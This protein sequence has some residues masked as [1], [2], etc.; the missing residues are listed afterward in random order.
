MKIH[1]LKGRSRAVLAALA[2]VWTFA[3]AAPAFAEAPGEARATAAAAPSGKEKRFPQLTLE[4][5]TPEQRP[6]GEEILK[7]SSVGLAG[8][9]NPMMRS[10]VMAERLFRLLDYLR[11]KTSLPRRL[12]EFA[13]LIQAR[14]WTSQVEWYAHHPLALKAGLSESVAA[15]LK[16]GK[17]PS[18]MKPDEAVVYDFCTELSTTHAVSDATFRRAKELLGEQ[19]VID[20]I[21]VSGTYVTVAM[22]LNA[23]EEGVPPG[24]KPPLEPLS[25]R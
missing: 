17:R 6:L 8:P 18:A 16:E 3:A 10:P 22:L 1:S 4:Q 19:Q 5:L 15:E 9:Y 20:L 24:K 21:A 11:F 25:N 14:L 7:V 23:A 2:A 13:I 12:N